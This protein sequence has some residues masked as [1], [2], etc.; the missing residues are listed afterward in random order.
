M[1]L[2]V[3]NQELKNIAILSEKE[4]FF[5]QSVKIASN[6]RSD[7][8]AAKALLSAYFSRGYGSGLTDDDLRNMPFELA[9]LINFMGALEAIGTTAEDVNNQWVTKVNKVA[10]YK[11]L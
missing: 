10:E 9:D 5:R 8:F 11:D 6:L 3:E 2:S 4:K 7:F 1:A